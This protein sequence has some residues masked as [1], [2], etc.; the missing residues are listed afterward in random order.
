VPLAGMVALDAMGLI[1]A[2]VEPALRDRLLVGRPI[3]GAVEARVPALQPGKQP[4][5]RGPVTTAELPV[6]QLP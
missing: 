3:V 1:L 2:D 6:N 4:F 5:E